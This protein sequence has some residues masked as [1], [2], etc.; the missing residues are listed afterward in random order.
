M[1]FVTGLPVLIDWKK[2]SYD[3][4]LVIVDWLTKMVHYKSVKIIFN[5]LGFAEVIIDKVIR[6]HR[7]PHSIVTNRRSLFNSKFWLLLC[8]FFAIK[9]KLS[10]TFHLQTDSQIEQQNS[11]IE[12]CLQ[13]F[14]NFEQN[15]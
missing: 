9:E 13:A 5:A 12:V 4:I 7:L 6:H 8:Y 10:T 1:D 14:V 11:T 3:S 15:D 2:D